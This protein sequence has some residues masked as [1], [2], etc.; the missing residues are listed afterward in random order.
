MGKPIADTEK[1]AY[2]KTDFENFTT[3]CNKRFHKNYLMVGNFYG[4]VWYK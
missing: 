2:R 1:L 3:T 4:N